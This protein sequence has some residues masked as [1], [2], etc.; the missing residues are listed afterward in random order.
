MAKINFTKEHLQSLERLALKMLFE[1]STIQ[2]TLG[3]PYNVCE[4]FEL[5]PNSLNNI[6]I[7]LGK[8]IH[9]IE[10]RDEWVEADPSILSDLKDKR[11]FINLLTG[12]KRFMAEREDNIKKKAELEAK[13]IMLKESQKTPEDKI[14]ELEAELS[15]LEDNGE[16]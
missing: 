3:S 10:E 13:L 14:K 12:Y 5:T 15:E 16:F 11:E 9:I 7:A 1:G 2:G 8:K 6:R 4:L